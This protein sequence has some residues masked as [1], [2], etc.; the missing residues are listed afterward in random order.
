MWNVLNLDKQALTS[1]WTTRK[2]LGLK[3]N[4]VQLC[5]IAIDYIYQQFLLIVLPTLMFVE[6]FI[7]AKSEMF[8]SEWQIF[9]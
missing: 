3:K 4:N 1:G 2:G 6:K 8:V 5:V 7:I 9:N